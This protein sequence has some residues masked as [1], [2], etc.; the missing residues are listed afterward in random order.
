M[1]FAHLFLY[2]SC[3]SI[4]IGTAIGNILWKGSDEAADLVSRELQERQFPGVIDSNAFLRRAYQACKRY[5]Y[6][7][8]Y[9][10]LIL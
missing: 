9:Q 4:I 10:E 6:L 2:T 8:I 7:A 3:F 5:R 1:A